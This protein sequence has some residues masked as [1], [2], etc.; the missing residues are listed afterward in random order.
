MTAPVLTEYH[1]DVS[2]FLSMPEPGTE[3]WEERHGDEVEAVCRALIRGDLHLNLRRAELW[4]E[5]RERDQPTRLRDLEQRAR[6]A[7]RE[8]HGEN[9]RAD[10][11]A[12]SDAVHEI[13]DGI[14]PVYNAALL[15]VAADSPTVALTEP[16]IGPAFD[17]SPTP[18]NIIAANIYEALTEAAYAEWRTIAD[19]DE[20]DED[21]AEA[22]DAAADALA[23]MD[24]ENTDAEGDDQTP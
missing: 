2:G 8:W 1:V 15:E 20:G 24:K 16:E 6:D 13:V 12:F 10:E 7:V 11:E 3:P 22:D 4:R 5:E 14:V 18:I 19:E 17:G 23:T 21:E 9:R